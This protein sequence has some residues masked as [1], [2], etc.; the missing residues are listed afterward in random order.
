MKNITAL[1]LL[2]IVFSPGPLE[3]EE[4]IKNYNFS[5]SPAFGFMYGMA[6]KLVYDYPGGTKLLGRLDWKMEPLFYFGGR[7]DLSRS[8]PLELWG[9]F[10]TFDMKFGIRGKT[11]FMEN[12]EWQAGNHGDITVFSIHDNHVRNM[13]DL[14]IRAGASFP[15]FGM[16]ALKIYGAFLYTRFSFSA[17]DGYRQYAKRLAAGIYEPGLSET[18]QYTGTVITCRQDWFIVSPGISLFYPFHR[19]FQAEID[20][21]AS[22]LVFCNAEDTHFK[23]DPVL[24]RKDYL[25]G[26]LFLEPG[27]TFSFTPERKLFFSLGF[28]WRYIRDVKGKTRSGETGENMSGLPAQKSEAGLSRFDVNVGAGWR[29]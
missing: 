27:I 22:P 10:F 28:S 2:V 7:V 14:G 9:G 23:R 29:F 12:R 11:G 18:E 6:G 19:L 8:R 17:V 15:L 26:G 24:E 13:T 25:R 16:M 1:C 5:A 4:L 3:G 21:A 20:L